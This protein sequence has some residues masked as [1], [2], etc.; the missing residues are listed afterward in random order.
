M[1]FFRF[2]VFGRI[3]GIRLSEL[4]L[5]RLSALR[6]SYLGLFGG[7]L[8]TRRAKK[9][10]RKKVLANVS[11]LWQNWPSPGGRR[12]PRPPGRRPR[13]SRR[14][15]APPCGPGWTGP[16]PRTPPRSRYAFRASCRSRKDF[17]FFSLLQIISDKI[18]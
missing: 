16:G 12:P 6:P 5:V 8:S 3:L 10:R 4:G 2:S 1:I 18:L 14:R 9:K 7:P 13:S 15:T 17:L 11:K